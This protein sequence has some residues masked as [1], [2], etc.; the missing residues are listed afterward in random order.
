[1]AEEKKRE[2][3]VKEADRKGGEKVARTHGHEFYEDIGH[4]GG[5]KGGKRV[6][7]LIEEGKEAEKK[8]SLMNGVKDSYYSGLITFFEK[9]R[10]P[11]GQ[12][13]VNSL[14]KRASGAP[15]DHRS[16]RAYAGEI[17][18]QH[19]GYRAC[20]RRRAYGEIMPGTIP[21]PR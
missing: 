5:E 9:F 16:A 7:E 21:K 14:R 13:Q 2:M 18:R 11:G 3:T 1:M 12:E 4:K 8:N 17:V 6:R 19:V 20:D 15:R 10:L